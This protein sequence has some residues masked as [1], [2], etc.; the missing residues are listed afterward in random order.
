VLSITCDNAAPN[1]VMVEH[2]GRSL[3]GFDGP[4]A[5]TRCFAHV[6]NLVAKSLLQSFDPPKKKK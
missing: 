5:R 2:L 6:V 3:P 4:L 1:D